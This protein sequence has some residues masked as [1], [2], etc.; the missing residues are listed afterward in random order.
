MKNLYLQLFEVSIEK[1]TNIVYL[2][3]NL[4]NIQIKTEMQIEENTEKKN[5]NKYID[6]AK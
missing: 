5:T 1:K 4:K 6:I 3:E 2:N